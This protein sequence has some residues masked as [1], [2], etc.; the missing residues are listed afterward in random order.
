MKARSPT[1]RRASARAA[2]G[3]EQQ[4]AAGIV[5]VVHDA[6]SAYPNTRSSGT[7]NTRAILNAT[8]SDGE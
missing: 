5:G 3:A 7:P 8:S 4:D 6:S 2:G 1:P